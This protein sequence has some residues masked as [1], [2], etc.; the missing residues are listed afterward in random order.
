MGVSLLAFRCAHAS[1]VGVLRANGAAP[2]PWSRVKVW[3]RASHRAN[4]RPSHA[5]RRKRCK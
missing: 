5:S 2:T 1:K 3:A 4:A